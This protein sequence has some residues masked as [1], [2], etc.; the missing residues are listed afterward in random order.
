MRVGFGYDIHQFRDGAS[1]PLRLGGVDIPNAPQLKGHSDGDPLIHAVIDAL[2]GAAG[3]GDI[4]KHFPPGEAA[5]A[6][7]DSR[8][9]LERVSALLSSR[10]IDIVNVDA[11]II[12]EY[13]PLSDHF[14]AIR[15]TI[16]NALG[17][18]D[19]RVNVKATTNEGLGVIGSGQAIA[20]MAVAL[21]E[22]HVR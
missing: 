17:M 14:L 2:L 4:G 5:T 16:A 9:L 20:A 7:I 22:E 12:A 13:P 6:G 11:T 10:R 1:G 15:E 8:V 19:D 3:E 18:D 21:I